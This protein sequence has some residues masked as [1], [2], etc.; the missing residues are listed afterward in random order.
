MT[1]PRKSGA[2][3]FTETV[4]K[5][6]VAAVARRDWRGTEYLPATGGVIVVANHVSHLD[7]FTLAHYV[8]DNGRIPRF[9]AK[10]S[11]FRIPIAGRIFAAAG[12][13]PVHRGADNAADS[14]RSAVAALADGEAIVIYPEGSLTRDPGLWPMRGKTGAARL[15]LL[16]GVPVIPIAQWGPQ[17]ILPPYARLPHLLPRGEV[18]LAA[19]PPVPLADLRDRPIDGALL[20]E[21][22]DRIMAAITAELAAIRQETA[23]A[24]RFDPR[25]AGVS[26]YGRPTSTGREEAS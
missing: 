17:R 3:R 21:A 26:E 25:V 16:T 1:G 15:A 13:I 6:L 23:P 24:I 8:N 2:Y 18:T 19:G 7:P 22:T 4:L 10:E 5:P 11:V 9:L 12:Q 14:L 20:K